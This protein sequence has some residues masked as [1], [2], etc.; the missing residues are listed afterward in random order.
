MRS[1]NVLQGLFMGAC[2]RPQDDYFVAGD[3]R[4]INRRL[5]IRKCLTVSAFR[6]NEVFN[7]FDA[8]G[9]GSVVNFQVTR[10][11]ILANISIGFGIHLVVE[12][13]GICDHLL[14]VHNNLLVG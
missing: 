14:W 5:L 6:F 8:L 1:R 11:E 4:I 7:P 10:T 9:V 3:E 2:A 12:A 13:I